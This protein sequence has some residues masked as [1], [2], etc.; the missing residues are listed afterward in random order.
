MDH[1][2]HS[3]HS[4]MNMQGQMHH[5]DDQMSMGEHHAG[6]GGHQPETGASHT[7]PHAHNHHEMMAADFR[8]R[9]YFSLVLAVPVVL[10]SPM[11]QSI[12]GVDW[13]FPGDSIVLFSLSTIIF[14]I[15]GWPFLKGS[16]DELAKKSPAMMTLIALAICVAYVYSSLSVFLIGGSDFFWELATLIGIMLL[17]HWIEMRS[18]MH[19]SK[20]LDEIMQLM[21]EEAHVL[22]EDGTAVDRPVSELKMHDRILVK[23]GEKIPI[24]GIVLEVRRPSMRP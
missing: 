10:L 18:V 15:G 5:Q 21:P 17:G 12:I 16:K 7:G 11:I 19:A 2:N 4:H 13:R 22:Q 6:H 3:E 1:Q 8:K 20:A 9:F 23:P 14:T 24:D